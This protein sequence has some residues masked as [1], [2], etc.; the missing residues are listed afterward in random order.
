MLLRHQLSIARARQLAQKKDFDGARQAIV[1]ELSTAPDNPQLLAAL[2]D[3]EMS[4][5]KPDQAGKILDRLRKAAPKSAAVD[6]I[7]GNL[8]MVGKN[9]GSARK[10]Y[11]SAWEKTPSDMIGLKVLDAMQRLPDTSQSDL[12]AFFADW[13]KRL[14]D[15]VTAKVAQAGLAMA[16]GNTQVARVQYESLLK[17]HPNTAIALN[18][19]AW[20]YGEKELKKALDASQRAYRLA[21]RSG[22]IADTYGWFLYKSGDT[23]KAREILAEATRL[24]PD[25]SE[26]RKHFDE[27]S[28]KPGGS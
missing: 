24:S 8:A 20:I 23:G 4:A 26:I 17:D 13:F 11:E 2:I 5:G 3:V 1:S 10:Y 12:D 22:E 15:S 25:N 6:V 19:L 7:A 27:V 9:Y 16:A 14:P 21:P 18:N 28:G